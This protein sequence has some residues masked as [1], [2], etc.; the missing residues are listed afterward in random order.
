MLSFSLNTECKVLQ[1]FHERIGLKYGA[2][3]DGISEWNEL[4]ADYL[5]QP[6]RSAMRDA[7]A[8]YTWRELYSDSA[9]RTEWENDVKELLPEYVTDLAEG[10]FFTK[11]TLLSQ[12]PQPGGALLRQITEQN[13][14][15]ERLNTIEAQKA[16]QDAEIEQ[17]R[18]LVELLGPEG[19]ILYRNQLNCEEDDAKG[20]IPFLPIPQG[21]DIVV[22]AN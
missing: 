21:S 3:K 6:L 7:A 16:A 14:Q 17:T 13:T 9:K 8:N 2:S 15:V 11:F 18:Q 5:G 1:Q 19:Y 12:V 22:P 10:D 4:L 20:C